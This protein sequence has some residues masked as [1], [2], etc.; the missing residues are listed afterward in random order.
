[1]KIV[2]VLSVKRVYCPCVFVNGLGKPKTAQ[3]NKIIL[4]RCAN[5]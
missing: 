5:F 4:H 1:M 3:N 2:Q